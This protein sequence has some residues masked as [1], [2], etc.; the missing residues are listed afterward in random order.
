MSTKQKW[1]ALALA[2]TISLQAIAPA[3]ALAGR[4]DRPTDSPDDP[5]QLPTQYEY[6][7]PEPGTGGSPMQIQWS[8]P[9]FCQLILFE[10]FRI[11]TL[12][13]FASGRA[14]REGARVMRDRASRGSAR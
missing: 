11:Q 2:M 9:W 7:D 6:G 10:V 13:T 5:N 8:D 12:P 4:G 1:L 14:P 3:T